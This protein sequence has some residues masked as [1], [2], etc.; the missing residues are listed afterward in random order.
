M[1][2]QKKDTGGGLKERRYPIE[3]AKVILDEMPIDP[4]PVPV[5][6]VGTV[7]GY[8]DLAEILMSWQTGSRLKLIPGVDR[9]YV[10]G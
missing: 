10:V 6:T 5:G 8:D 4:Y 3:G 7:E 9:Y 2:P 1:I